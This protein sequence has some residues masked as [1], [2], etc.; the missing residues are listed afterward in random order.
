[1]RIRASISSILGWIF[2]RQ[3]LRSAAVAVRA[4]AQAGGNSNATVIIVVAEIFI[5]R[6]LATR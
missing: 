4:M 2:A 3:A 5:T 6:I 1:L